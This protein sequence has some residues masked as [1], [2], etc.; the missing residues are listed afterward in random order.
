MRYAILA[1]GLLLAAFLAFFTATAIGLSPYNGQECVDSS[2]CGAYGPQGTG[3]GGAC[4]SNTRIVD[5]NCQYSNPP[6]VGHMSSMPCTCCTGDFSG[7]ICV[8]F[9]GIA[10]S[11]P[12]PCQFTEPGTTCGELQNG[13]CVSQPFQGSF[14]CVCQGDGNDQGTCAFPGCTNPI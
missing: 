13:T 2:S 7:T 5:S 8:N 6:P 9:T 3:T 11:M 4:T 14:I 1:S 12:P 10:G